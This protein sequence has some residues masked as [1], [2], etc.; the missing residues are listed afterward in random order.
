MN[1]LSDTSV[2]A[3]A[4][5]ELPQRRVSAR[6]FW[7]GLVLAMGLAALN[8]WIEIVAS[9]HFLGGVQMPLGAL[10]TLICLIGVNWLL[11]AVGQRSNI[12]PFSPTELLTIYLMSLFA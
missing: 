7:I 10:F 1:P 12:T 9:V 6:A 4:A 11:R 3:Q 2:E 5:V 8:C